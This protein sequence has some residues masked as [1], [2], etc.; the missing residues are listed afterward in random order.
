MIG[1]IRSV[2]V[3]SQLFNA[4]NAKPLTPLMIGIEVQATFI[5]RGGLAETLEF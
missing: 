1:D 2:R 4:A 3:Q 5:A